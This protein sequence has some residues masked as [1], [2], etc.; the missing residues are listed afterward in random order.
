MT[1]V[2]ELRATGRLI[3]PWRSVDA[4]ALHEAAAESIATVGRWLPWCHAGYARADSVAWIERCVALWSC[5]DEYTFAIFDDAGAR[6]LGGIGLNRFDRTRRTANLGYWVRASAQGRGIATESARC[7]AA[8]GFTRGFERIE[9]LVAPENQPSRRVAEKIGAQC[10]G[11]VAARLESDGAR[12]SACVYALS[13]P[14]QN[15]A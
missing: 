13:P 10:E 1:A 6:M 2:V 14:A 7:V 11:I 5:E 3:R 12:L 8:F 4:D 9:I 15:A